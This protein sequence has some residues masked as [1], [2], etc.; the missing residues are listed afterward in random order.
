[1]ARVSGVTVGDVAF[2]V[3]CTLVMTSPGN[4]DRRVAVE[5]EFSKRS[6]KSIHNARNTGVDVD[7]DSL[8]VTNGRWHAEMCVYG[9]VPCCHLPLFRVIRKIEGE[10]NQGNARRTSSSVNVAVL[11]RSSNL[12]RRPSSSIL[13]VE[14]C[15]IRLVVDCVR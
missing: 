2:E 7:D 12:A 14:A 10:G 1:M 13:V 8:P 15:D 11:K 5:N 4:S 3:A 9:G 6:K